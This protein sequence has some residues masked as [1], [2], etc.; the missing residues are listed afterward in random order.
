MVD[1]LMSVKMSQDYKV[2][3]LESQINS[4]EAS[5]SRDESQNVSVSQGFGYEAILNDLNEQ[6]KML[7]QET[8]EFHLNS[9]HPFNATTFQRYLY[10]GNNNHEAVK[11]IFIL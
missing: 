7:R 8:K 6:V 9:G 2:Q 3:E 1:E 5:C 10:S 4:L 11:E